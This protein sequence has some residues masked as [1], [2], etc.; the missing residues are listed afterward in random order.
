MGYSK[1]CEN[2]IQTDT[3]FMSVKCENGLPYY[4]PLFCPSEKGC[5]Y[6]HEAGL[7]WKL[8]ISSCL[9]L[10]SSGKASAQAFNLIC[11]VLVQIFFSGLMLPLICTPVIFDHQKQKARQCRFVK[12]QVNEDSRNSIFKRER[13]EIREGRRGLLF[14]DSPVGCVWIWLFSL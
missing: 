1:H 12:V 13:N 10:S 6:N 7:L 4:K 3:I 5:S 8:Y 2:A 14:F 9:F 11:A